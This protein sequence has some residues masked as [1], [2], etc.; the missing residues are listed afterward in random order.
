M[1]V[2]HPPTAAAAKEAWRVSSSFVVLDD[3]PR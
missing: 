2:G 1:V 3:Q